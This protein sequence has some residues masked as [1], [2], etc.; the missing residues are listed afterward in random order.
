MNK[1][2]KFLIPLLIL[3]V[4]LSGCVGPQMGTLTV[5]VVDNSNDQPIEDAFVVIQRQNDSFTS[6]AG[7]TNALGIFSVQLDSDGYDIF[8]SKSG[9]EDW[10]VGL[11]VSANSLKNVEA[12][13]KAGS[14]HDLIVD[15]LQVE[16]NGD[17][18]EVIFSSALSVLG[19]R[20][21][22]GLFVLT[23][24]LFDPDGQFLQMGDSIYDPLVMDCEVCPRVGVGFTP[25]EVIS[26]VYSIIV[27]VDSNDEV[28][29]INESNNQE[30][31]HF[32]FPAT[33]L[34]GENLGIVTIGTGATSGSGFVEVERN[35]ITET[36]TEG[37]S[38][39]SIGG[40]GDLQGQDVSVKLVSILQSNPDVSTYTAMFELY[41][42][43]NVLIDTRNVSVDA[44]LLDEFSIHNQSFFFT[45]G[46]TIDGLTGAGDVAGEVLSVEFSDLIQSEGVYSGYF[47]LYDDEGDLLDDRTVSVGDKLNVAFGGADDLLENSIEIVTLAIGAT[48]GIGYTEVIVEEIA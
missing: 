29:E 30:E 18:D 12:K 11:R 35:S 38:I 40:F 46:E 8:V 1:N 34:L 17:G 9:Y 44:D 47:E 26:G 19:D 32:I 16:F 20:T 13:L 41:D 3:F 28:E 6:A 21:T 42:E 36:Y 14:G 22:M 37:E 48:T 15:D 23:V 7:N 10:S 45:E 4:F 43:A 24:E 33:L 27:T 5:H 39:E 25:V 2:L 31:I